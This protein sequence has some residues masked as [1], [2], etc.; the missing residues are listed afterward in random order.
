MNKI[1][2]NFDTKTLLLLF[3]G[4]TKKFYDSETLSIR[5]FRLFV[6]LVTGRNCE[7]FLRCFL[8]GSL[9]GLKLT[10]NV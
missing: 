7:E 3:L 8:S 10:W 6:D 9:G 2:I 5:I 1:T 4:C